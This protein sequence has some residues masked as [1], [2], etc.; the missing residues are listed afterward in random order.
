MNAMR[1]AISAAATT[2]LQ[3]TEMSGKQSFC[4]ASDFIGFSGHFPDY[5]IL[6]AVLQVL[7]AQLIAE[8]VMERP[9]RV[10]ALLRAKF[11]RQLRPEEKIDVCVD[12]RDQD[13]NLCCAVTLHVGDEKAAGFSL[14]L[15]RGS[16]R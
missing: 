6:P 3:R 1:K 13:E 10:V 5:P 16:I 7:L 9:L 2:P 8:G 12:C 4:F 11:I 15:S 14:I